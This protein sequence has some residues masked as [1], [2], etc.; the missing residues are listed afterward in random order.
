MHQGVIGVARRQELEAKIDAVR[1][2]ADPPTKTI[3]AAI[4][5]Q[6]VAENPA[7]EMPLVVKAIKVGQIFNAMPT[8]PANV[9]SAATA[10]KAI[11][12]I[13]I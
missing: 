11:R 4:H 8:V 6:M 7:T 2:S 1:T 9:E 12:E 10:L 5:A 13:V 3:I